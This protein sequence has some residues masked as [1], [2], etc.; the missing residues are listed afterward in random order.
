MKY[1]TVGEEEVEVPA[2]KFKAIRVDM[3]A[4]DERPPAGTT[5]WFALGHGPVKILTRNPNGEERIQH[6]KAFI[7]AKK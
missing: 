2:G 4:G 6:L 5:Y 7:P 1:T 3:V